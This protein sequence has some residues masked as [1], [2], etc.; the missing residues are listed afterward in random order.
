[1]AVRTQ[2]IKRRLR[3]LRVCELAIIAG[4]AWN[5]VD[6]QDV[7][8]HRYSAWRQHLPDQ[9]E[10]ESLIIELG[11]EVLVFVFSFAPF[12]STLLGLDFRSSA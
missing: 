2:Q 7:V 4:F 8:Q 3:E 1:M 11:E 6:K 5:R 9:D 12:A 10:I